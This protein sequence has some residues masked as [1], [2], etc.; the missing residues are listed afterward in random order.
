MR[1]AKWE[2]ENSQV[3]MNWRF[4][5]RLF[6]FFFCGCQMTIA[7]GGGIWSG[8]H[9]CHF[10]GLNKIKEKSMEWMNVVEWHRVTVIRRSFRRHFVSSPKNA[11]LMDEKGTKRRNMCIVERSNAQSKESHSTVSLA[12]PISQDKLTTSF[13]LWMCVCVCIFFLLSSLR[14]LSIASSI[15]RASFYFLTLLAAHLPCYR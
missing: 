6:F 13:I 11:V 12:L 15:I 2:K 1:K 7:V 9:Y 8:T 10:Y 14:C 5:F 3:K 4:L